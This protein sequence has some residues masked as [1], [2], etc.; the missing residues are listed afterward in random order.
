MNDSLTMRVIG[1]NQMRRVT[2]IGNAE[3]DSSHCA[4]Y[5][6]TR[7][8]VRFGTRNSPV[9]NRE[10]TLLSVLAFFLLPQTVFVTVFMKQGNFSCQGTDV[11]SDEC[12]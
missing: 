9:V 12:R 4:V 11:Y 3:W 7:T 1:C 10:Q 6:S 2:V 5:Q 8:L